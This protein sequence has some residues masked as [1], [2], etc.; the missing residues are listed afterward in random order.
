M[1]RPGALEPVGPGDPTACLQTEG[2][3]VAL[4]RF[5]LAG[6]PHGVYFPVRGYL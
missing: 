4:K 6:E 1:I 5:M 2:S 3:D